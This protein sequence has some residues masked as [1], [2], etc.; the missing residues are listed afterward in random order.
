MWFFAG[1]PFIHNF[2]IFIGYSQLRSLHF[3]S[4]CQ[5]SF[6]KFKDGRFILKDKFVRNCRFIRR[7]R[8]KSKLLHLVC[9]GKSWSRGSLF[10][11]IGKSNGQIR[12]K[13]QFS[14][15]PGCFFLDHGSRFQNHIPVFIG[16][17]LFCGKGK[18]SALQYPVSILFF[19]QDRYF[20]LLAVILP[21]SIPGNFRCLLIHI[22]QVNFPDFPVQH[23]AFRSLL[24]FHIVFSKGK[25]RQLRNACFIC[26]NRGNQLI[27][28]IIILALSVCRFDV[29]QG[30][31]LKGYI[32]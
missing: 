22:G 12:L 16:N 11:Y 18:H 13:S 9:G 2:A 7:F 24:F 5:G 10:H 19:L 3:F 28:L 17:I 25:A 30:I 15:L 20:R 8:C 32:F 29:L 26:G 6:G 4:I 31:Y 1:Y 14:I 23:I 27:L 21:V